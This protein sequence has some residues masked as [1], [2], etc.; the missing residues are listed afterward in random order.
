MLGLIGSPSIRLPALVLAAP[1]V[2][3]VPGL[4]TPR[5]VP[6]VT[7]R[8]ALRDNLSRALVAVAPLS[9]LGP[10]RCCLLRVT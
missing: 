5:P 4:T 8:D 10:E 2:K 3:G 9:E 6:R 7:L 1:S